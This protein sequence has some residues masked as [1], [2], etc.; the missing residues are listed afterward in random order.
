ME[1]NKIYKGGCSTVYAY[2]CGRASEIEY[3]LDDGFTWNS[4]PM[5]LGKIEYMSAWY[6]LK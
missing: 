6:R 4:V 2:H 1:K 5:D 3:S